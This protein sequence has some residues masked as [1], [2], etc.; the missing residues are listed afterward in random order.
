MMSIII[1][2]KSA[3]SS[4]VVIKNVTNEPTFCLLSLCDNETIGWHSCTNMIVS[5]LW[6]KWSSCVQYLEESRSRSGW[7]ILRGDITHSYKWRWRADEHMDATLLWVCRNSFM[8]PMMH[9]PSTLQCPTYS[10]RNPA[11]I[12]S[13][14]WN[15][16]GIHRNP[17]EF[18]WNPAGIQSFQWNKNGIKQTKVEILIYLSQF[19]SCADIYT[20]LFP[21]HF[22]S[23]FTPVLYP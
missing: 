2:N 9:D 12:R 18:H 4:S 8:N 11:G 6:F 22:Y 13:F 14:Q 15:S 3:G 10:C 21:C 5:T 23:S 16:G 20:F 17:Q 1:A 19:L 7:A